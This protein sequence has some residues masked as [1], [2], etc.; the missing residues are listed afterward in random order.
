MSEPRGQKRVL[1]AAGDEERSLLRGLFASGQVPGWQAEEAES[2]ER[3]RFLVQLDPPDVLLLDASLCPEGNAQTLGWLGGEGKVP[4]VFLGPIDP[5]LILNALSHGAHQWLPRELALKN[6]LLLAVVLHQGLRLTELHRQARTTAEALAD[7]QQRVSRLVEL[8]WE[9][10]PGERQGRWFSQRHM[11]ERL[12]EELARARRHGGPLTVVLGEILPSGL[13]IPTPEQA[14]ELAR[15]AA[16]FIGQNKRRSD[17]AGQYG[18]N[19]FMMVLPRVDETEAV[20]CCRRL[21]ALLAHPGQA[22][23]P[24]MHTHFG[25]ASFSADVSTVQGLLR[26]AEDALEQDKT[27]RTDEPES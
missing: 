19:G 12:D 23:V 11:L 5:P 6:P 21:K 13:A 26:R 20:S 25:L 10:T 16:R 7:C 22:A 8:L 4:V 15:Q 9:T 18:L 27:L 17:V 1:V 24:P 3:A 2:L 14:Q